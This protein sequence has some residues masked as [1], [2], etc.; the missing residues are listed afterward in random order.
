MAMLFHGRSRLSASRTVLVTSAVV[1]AVIIGVR[2]TGFLQPLELSGFD[3]LTRLRPS[4]KPDDRLLIVG[5]HDQD[6]H[7]RETPLTDRTVR[8]LLENLE[9]LAPRAIGL[10]IIRDVPVGS[11]K[12]TILEYLQLLETM[13]RTE[14]LIAVCR[15]RDRF[16][17]GFLPP[18]GLK[19]DQIGAVNLEA[20]PDGILR[21]ALLTVLPP[22]NA[23]GE[24]ASVCEDSDAALGF[25][26]QLAL[27][28][29]NVEGIALERSS[30]GS[31]K[32]G[33]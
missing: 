19:A 3:Q 18:G 33:S 21:R 2:Q 28:Y 7:A 30:N 24:A 17:H 1:T 13:Q 9:A 20:D 4:E 27:R 8:L 16:D 15:V 23:S 5:I 25:G 6:S 14:R 10:D 32:L 12:N 31:L 22:T 29:L 11:G 26:L